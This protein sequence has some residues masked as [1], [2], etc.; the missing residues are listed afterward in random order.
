VEVGGERVMPIADPIDRPSDP[1]RRP[2]NQ[3]EFRTGA[4][5]DAEIAADI[6]RHRRRCPGRST[7]RQGSDAA[8]RGGDRPHEP[9]RRQR[10]IA[11]MVRKGARLPSPDEYQKYVENDR[12]LAQRY[13]WKPRDS[14]RVDE[15]VAFMRG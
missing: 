13:G 11:E 4:V 1:S 14:A 15:L 10:L 7:D 5:A 8:P 12:A 2:G 9:E 3:R 6:A